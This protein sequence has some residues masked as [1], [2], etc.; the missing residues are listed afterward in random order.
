MPKPVVQAAPPQ[1]IESIRRL[2]DAF[3]GDVLIGAGTVTTPR[4]VE[5]IAGAGKFRWS[6]YKRNEEYNAAIGFAVGVA[7]LLFRLLW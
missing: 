4:Q 5:D 6:V 7:V 2:T 1:P 3:G